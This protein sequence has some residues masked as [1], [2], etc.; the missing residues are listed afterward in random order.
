M[1]ATRSAHPIILYLITLTL[2]SEEYKLGRSSLYC[3]LHASVP[4]SLRSK[5]FSQRLL[6]KIPQYLRFV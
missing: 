5:Y 3:L 2:F 1:R 4:S 6:L